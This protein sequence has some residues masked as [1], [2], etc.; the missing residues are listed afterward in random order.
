MRRWLKRIAV[1][2]LLLLAV[3]GTWLWF[4]YLEPL[5]LPADGGPHRHLIAQSLAGGT[6]TVEGALAGKSGF[7]DGIGGN[8]LL[9]KP[10]RLTK[11]D[12]RTV[13]FA[14]INNHAIRT[15]DR[16]GTVKTL[17]GGPTKRGHADGPASDARLESPHGVAV[18]SDGA[19][20]V[21]DVGSNTI[22]L[23]VPAAG[24]YTVSTFAGVPGGGFQDGPA[25]TA[26][27]NAPHAVVWCPDGGLLVADIGNARIRR[28]ADGQV[29]TVA[30]DGHWGAVDGQPGRLFMPMDICLDADGTLWIADCGSLS[31]RTWHPA[32]GLATPFPQRPKMAMP[33][34]IGRW[35]DRVV[36]AEM[37]AQR[38]V[39]LDGKDGSISTLYGDGEKGIGPNQLH[40]PAAVLVDGN[41]LWIADL[42][43]HRIVVG[44]LPAK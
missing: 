13:V 2:L 26:K 27:F 43:N 7:V 32:R 25:A 1:T 6:E 28:I 3:G 34:G 19:I 31:I 44:E 11:L 41:R 21:A 33:H 37:S 16:D 22:R 40:R 14:D 5:Y 15:I 35:G 4:A 12:E 20:A 42:Y 36:V 30:G 18:R 24:T 38:I 23:L 8:A 29:S 10:I 17:V 39:A 9:H